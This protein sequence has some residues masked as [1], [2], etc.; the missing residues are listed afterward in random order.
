MCWADI[1]KAGA[2]LAGSAVNG[3]NQW[4]ATITNNRMQKAELIRQGNVQDAA[5]QVENLNAFQSAREGLNQHSLDNLKAQ[6]TVKQAA[7]ESNLEGRTIERELRVA[8]NVGL[9]TRG[10]IQENYQRDYANIMA[11]RIANREQT[12]RQIEAIRDPERPATLE[13]RFGLSKEGLKSGIPFAFLDKENN[14]KFAQQLW[15]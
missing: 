1:A 8:E 6:S 2:G 5:L 14:S 10:Q 12:I 13:Q 3:Q 15:G 7:A 9:K 11:N 4:A